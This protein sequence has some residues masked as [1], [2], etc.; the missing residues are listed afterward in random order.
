MFECAAR[1]SVDKPVASK[2]DRKIKPKDWLHSSDPKHEEVWDEFN[3]AIHLWI[4]WLKTSDIP[5]KVQFESMGIVYVDA[6][7]V[8]VP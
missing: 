8:Q 1:R 4:S 5:G 3:E 7:E 2:R 6:I